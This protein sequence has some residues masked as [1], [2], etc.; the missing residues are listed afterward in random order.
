MLNQDLDYLKKIAQNENYKTEELLS[1]EKIKVYFAE[2]ALVKLD[3]KQRRTRCQTLVRAEISENLGIN[4]RSF[5]D[6][7]N[8]MNEIQDAI[9]WGGGR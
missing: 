2:K 8:K 7:I 4:A 6:T 9:I 5:D 3:D 1:P